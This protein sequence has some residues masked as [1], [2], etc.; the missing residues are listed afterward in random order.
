MAF[1]KN[2]DTEAWD[3]AWRKLSPL[4]KGDAPEE[5]LDQ[6]KLDPCTDLI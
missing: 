6:R 2:R 1:G 3:E 5:E 4:T